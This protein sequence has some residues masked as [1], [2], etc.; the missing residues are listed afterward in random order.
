MNQLKKLTA[1]KDL[2]FFLQSTSL[3]QA[4]VLKEGFLGHQGA[5][6]RG[7]S[8]KETDGENGL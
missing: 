1:F 5:P 4:L 3:L 8:Q 7:Y 2:A 6:Q